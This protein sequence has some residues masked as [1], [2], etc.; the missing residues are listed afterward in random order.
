MGN[1]AYAIATGRHRLLHNAIMKTG[2]EITE[3]IKDNP[4]WGLS[5]FTSHDTSRLL[6]FAI[7][8]Y[9]KEMEDRLRT[10]PMKDFK[11]HREMIPTREESY[12]DLLLVDENIITIKEYK[13][14]L[15]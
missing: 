7:C 11:P 3:I 9:R 4:A 10:N 6:E 1:I 8:E 2:R 13:K 12:K 14:F 15:S 5:D